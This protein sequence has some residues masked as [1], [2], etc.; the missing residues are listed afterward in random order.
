L[1]GL[2]RM[3]WRSLVENLQGQ[4]QVA[5]SLGAS[6]FAIWRQVLLPQLAPSISTL[7][8]VAAVWACGDF[9][10]SKLIA[11]KDLTLGMMTETLISSGYR[12]GLATVLS[13]V[14]LVASVL[15]FLV[16]KGLGY[17]LSQ[18]SVS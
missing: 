4:R 1:P 12:L 5:E 7:A 10:I 2:W 9:A 6:E 18:K 17:V 3:G 11:S 8:G 15:C 13:V 14:L 16:M